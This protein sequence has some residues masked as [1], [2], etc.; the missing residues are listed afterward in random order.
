[1]AVWVSGKNALV[2]ATHKNVVEL[3]YADS[4]TNVSMV[5]GGS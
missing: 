3:R 5:G 1:M 2:P 4:G